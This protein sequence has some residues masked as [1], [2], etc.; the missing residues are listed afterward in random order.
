MGTIA[1]HDKKTKKLLTEFEIDDDVINLLK[2][3]SDPSQTFEDAIRG[4]LKKE[5]EKKCI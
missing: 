1:L 3:Q 4:G 5:M 2:K